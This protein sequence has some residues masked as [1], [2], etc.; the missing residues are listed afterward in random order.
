MEFE[1]TVE[2]SEGFIG[3]EAVVIGI[4]GEIQEKLEMFAVIWF[5]IESR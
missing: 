1:K 4:Y 3:G 2:D 5:I